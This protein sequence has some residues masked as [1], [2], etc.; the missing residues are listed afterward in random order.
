MAA[1][2]WARDGSGT[3]RK[4]K[5]LWIRDAGGAARLIKELW[6][7]DGG[8][9]ARKIFEYFQVTGAGLS[10]TILT[11]A[12]QPQLRLQTDGTVQTR[13]SNN[14]LGADNP[15]GSPTVAGIGSNYWILVTLGAGS[16]VMSGTTGS[17]VSL[18][19]EYVLTMNAAANGF[20]V[21]RNASYTI[22]SDAGGA[23]AVG[24]GTMHFESDRT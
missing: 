11:T 5:E 12:T 13:L 14:T 8:G 15:W 24:S 19:S 22:Y 1:E 3:P 16:G 17:L 21:S 18:S 10:S 9:V 7:R 4:I 23:N 2:L 6:A 20:S